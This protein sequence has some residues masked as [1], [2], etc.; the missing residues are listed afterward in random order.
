M[1]SFERLHYGEAEAGKKIRTG[2]TTEAWRRRGLTKD[3]D[4]KIKELTTGREYGFSGADKEG[5]FEARR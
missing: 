1:M 3:S 2:I 4:K 5:Q